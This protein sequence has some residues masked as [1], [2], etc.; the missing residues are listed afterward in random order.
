M[1]VLTAEAREE[2]LTEWMRF[3]QDTCATIKPDL[4]ATIAALDDWIN[5]NA[6]AVNATIPQPARAQLSQSQ[7]SSIYTNILAKRYQKGQ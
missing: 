1:A 4:R 2:I 3:N 7:K 6:A 5:A